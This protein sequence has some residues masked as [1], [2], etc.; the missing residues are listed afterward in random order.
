MVMLTP[1]PFQEHQYKACI[2]IDNWKCTS[3]VCFCFVCFLFSIK[4]LMFHRSYEAY[5]AINSPD[6]H[7]AY[8]QICIRQLTTSN[9]LQ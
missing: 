2:R 6:S 8:K 4:W 1:L 3:F 5:I 9:E 7:I